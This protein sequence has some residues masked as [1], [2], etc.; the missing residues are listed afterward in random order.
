M[1][2]YYKLYLPKSRKEIKL[3]ISIPRDYDNNTRFDTLYLLDGQNAFK[4]SHATYHRSIRATKYMGYMAAVT[5]NRMIGVAVYNAGSEMGRINEYTPFPIKQAADEQWHHHNVKICHAF[6]DD[7]IHVIIP[8]IDQKYPTVQ[9]EDHRF[10]YGSSLAAIT[11]IYLGYQ[12][13]KTFGGIG[14]FSTACFLC[15]EEI[16]KFLNKKIDPSVKLFLYVGR[17]EISD[18]SFDATLY[19][20]SSLSLYHYCNKHGANVRLVVSE[21]G[22]HCEACWEKQLLD[23]FS[24]LYSDQIL[25]HL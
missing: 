15:P 5:G 11:A 21:N 13:P 20:A 25:Y 8:Y 22:T 23:F 12:Y 16:K 9:K 1:I 18:N 3:E 14:A 7:F 19:Y 24:F 17:K 4:D 2:E 10:I 6:C